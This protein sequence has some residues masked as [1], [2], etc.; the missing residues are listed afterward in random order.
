MA[1]PWARFYGT[2]RWR[3]RSLLN[4]KMHKHLCQECLK[5]G[6]VEPATISHHINEWRENST[7]LD[8]W[9]GELT[10]LCADCHAEIHGYNK[11]RGFITDIGPD[12]W[13]IDPQN[14]ANQI[15][16]KEVTAAR[17]QQWA[18]DLQNRKATR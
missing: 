8:F 4:L 14:P 10:A 1:T 16:L 6:K 3:R 15:E 12:G 5:V 17:K 9:C 13:P 11:S 2:E 18:R 7:E